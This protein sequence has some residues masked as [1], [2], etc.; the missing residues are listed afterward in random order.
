MDWISIISIDLP[1]K[2]LNDEEAAK[3]IGHFFPSVQDK[4]LNLLQLEQISDSD[5][6]LI[7][8]SID[9]K[10]DELKVVSFEKAVEIKRIANI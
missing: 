9:Q 7:I 6:E 8:A 5:N 10:T 4:L 3:Q 1:D 2:E